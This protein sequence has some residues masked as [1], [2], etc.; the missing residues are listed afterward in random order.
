MGLSHDEKTLATCF[1]HD[2]GVSLIG[3]F[4]KYQLK[5]MTL[6]GMLYVALQGAP[7]PHI[8]T[9]FKCPASTWIGLAGVFFLPP[10]KNILARDVSSC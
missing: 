4:D 6:K 7:C 5:R 2:L 9:K 10:D 8:S 1:F 3:F